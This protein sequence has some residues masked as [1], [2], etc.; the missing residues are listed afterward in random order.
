MQTPMLS[1]LIAWCQYLR[2]VNKLQQESYHCWSNMVDT[3]V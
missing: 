2:V 3:L 1:L